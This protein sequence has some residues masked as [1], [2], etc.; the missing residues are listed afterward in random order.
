M[1]R[2][3]LPNYKYKISESNIELKYTSNPNASPFINH[4][5]FMNLNELKK[6][7]HKNQQDWYKYKIYTNPYEFIHT[8]VHNNITISKLNPV[9]RSFYKFIEMNK[10]FNI[11][12]SFK[13]KPINTLHIAEG[14]GGF[15]EAVLYKRKSLI[16]DDDITGI[17]LI[18][19][20]YGVPTWKSLKDKLKYYNKHV[21]LESFPQSTGDLYEP[22]HFEYAYVKYKHSRHLITADGGFDFSSDY[23]NQET[24]MLR[25]LF[26]QFMYAVVCQKK[27]GTF[28]M[29]IFDVFKKA[30]IELLFLIN[31]FYEK[32]T[33]VKPKTSRYANSEKYIVC[34]GFKYNYVKSYYV[35]FHK[36]LIHMKKNKDLYLTQILNVK[37]SK[38][39]I[40]RIQEINSTFGIIQMD[41][42]SKTILLFQQEYKENMIDHYKKNNTNKCIEWCNQYNIPYS[43]PILYKSF[44]FSRHNNFTYRKTKYNYQDSI[45][46]PLNHIITPKTNNKI[47]KTNE[48]ENVSSED[49]L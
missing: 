36:L 21:H 38:M 39:F 37:L 40:D 44:P 11:L 12:D 19:S 5:F 6:V 41:I 17:T 42:I 28:I 43:H 1:Y 25:L 22:E 33:I 27:G 48:I 29:K 3:Q 49:T 16:Y 45:V 35:C 13:K 15:I 32:V 4:S 2:L 47:Y 31:S 46:N 24:S 34:E 20:D 14:P 7:I 9:S 26:T 10:D 30:T 23:E 18:S 8:V